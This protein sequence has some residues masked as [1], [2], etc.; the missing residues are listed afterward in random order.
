MDPLPKTPPENEIDWFEALLRLARFLRSPDGCPWDREQT[1]ATFG[2]YAREEA[3]EYVEALDSGKADHMAEEWGDTFFVLMASAVAAESEG[4]FT[5]Q[6]ALAK[7]HEKMVRRHD[8]VFG[9]AKA[10]TP[11][12]AIEAWNRMKKGEKAN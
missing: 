4:L 12:E 5:V 10:A 3:D 9:D 8:H 7:A 2:R 1:T 6:D 11:E